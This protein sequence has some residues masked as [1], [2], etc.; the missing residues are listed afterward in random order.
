LQRLVQPLTADGNGQQKNST[1]NKLMLHVFERVD[2]ESLT[3]AANSLAKMLQ[4]NSSLK[5]LCFWAKESKYSVDSFA[6]ALETNRTLESLSVRGSLL[7]LQRLLQPLTGD[8]NGQQRNATLSKL[9]L[10]IT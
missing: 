6:E 7:H 3:V 1:L 4:N 8:A 10:Q 2:E 5:E 9:R